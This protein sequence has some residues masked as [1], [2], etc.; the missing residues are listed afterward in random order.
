MGNSDHPQF[1]PE[2]PCPEMNNLG[3]RIIHRN[4]GGFSY[5]TMVWWPKSQ[6]PNLG[7]ALLRAYCG[8]HSQTDELLQFLREV[9]EVNQGD[10]HKVGLVEAAQRAM[11]RIIEE[12]NHAD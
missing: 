1:G 9:V 11:S 2:I 5:W 8:G 7:S 4:E 6:E 12:A 10:P 3:Y